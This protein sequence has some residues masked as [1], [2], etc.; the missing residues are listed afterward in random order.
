MEYIALVKIS[1]Y[2]GILNGNVL[3]FLCGLVWGLD[4]SS[5]DFTLFSTNISVLVGT[6]A[7]RRHTSGFSESTPR[8]NPQRSPWLKGGS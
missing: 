2:L 8:G 3:F 7:V 1:H 4:V 5:T 6:K